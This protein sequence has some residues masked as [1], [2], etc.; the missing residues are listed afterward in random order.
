MKF[1]IF[2]PSTR[3]LGPSAPH[4]DWMLAGEAEERRW[5]GFSRSEYENENQA[6][7]TVDSREIQEWHKG[8]RTVRRRMSS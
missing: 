5:L 8:E 1:V 2:Q 4:A 6:K 7:D 3:A